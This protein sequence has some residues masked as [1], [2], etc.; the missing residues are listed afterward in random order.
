MIIDYLLQVLDGNQTAHHTQKGLQYS[1]NCPFCNDSRSRLFINID[2]QMFYCHNCE[3]A[4]TLISFISSYNKITWK[5]ALDVYREFQ[6]YN[7]QLP[8]SLEQE[9]VLKLMDKKQYEQKKI[10]HDLPEE[11]IPVEEATG[12]AG[13]KA[14]EYLKERGISLSMA[15][16]YYIG[17]CAEGKYENRIVMPDFENGELVYWQ[18]RTWEPKPKD[19]YLKKFYKKVLNPSLTKEQIDSGIRAV[20]KSEVISNI[21]LILSEGAAVICEGKMDSYTIGDL[22][23]CIHGKHLSDHQFIKLISNKDKI[24]EVYVMLDGDAYDKALLTAKRIFQY[25]ENVYICKI[26]ADADPNSLGRKRCLEVI[27]KAVKFSPLYSIREKIML[28]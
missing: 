25:M 27:S 7:F 22:G 13:R 6:G 8:E 12:K 19:A 23:A 18:A 16:R 11:F 1:F 24:S 2:N 9:I 26:P 28:W 14:I 17:Y 15:E 10:V 20:D 4:G 5:D 3:S 21:D